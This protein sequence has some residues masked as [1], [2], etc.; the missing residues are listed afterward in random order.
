MMM[1]AKMAIAVSSATMVPLRGL[2]VMNIT[3]KQNQSK[4][5]NP[6]VKQSRKRTNRG[7]S[8]DFGSSLKPFF[9]NLSVASVLVNPSDMLY[10]QLYGVYSM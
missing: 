1:T 9:F 6:V 5:L 2:Y 3:T 8:L 4:G 10:L 7:H